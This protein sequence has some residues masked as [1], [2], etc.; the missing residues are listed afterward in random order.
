ML[1]IFRLFPTS[2][3]CGT[4][5][6]SGNVRQMDISELGMEKVGHTRGRQKHNGPVC[7]PGRTFHESLWYCRLKIDD[8][9]L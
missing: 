3:H 2:S 8:W 4:L 6:G 1:E 5:N 7:S 9:Q